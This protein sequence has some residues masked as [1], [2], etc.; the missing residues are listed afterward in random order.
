M[1]CNSNI[2]YTFARFFEKRIYDLRLNELID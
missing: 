1:F 2:L